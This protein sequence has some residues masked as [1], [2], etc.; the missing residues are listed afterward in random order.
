MMPRW[1][2]RHQEPRRLVHA[3]AEALIRDHGA[4]ASGKPASASGIAK[5]EIVRRLELGPGYQAR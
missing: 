3:D 4:T 2:R 1:L 5:G